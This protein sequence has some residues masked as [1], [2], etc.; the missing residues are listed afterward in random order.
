MSKDNVVSLT[1]PGEISDPLTDLLRQCACRLIEAADSAEFEEHL[2]VFSHDLL[3]VGRQRMVRNGYLPSRRILTGTG[4][5]EVC[6]PKSRSP[7]S[8]RDTHSDLWATW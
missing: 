4:A 8:G 6:V 1:A 3:P 5:V 7:A 2:S